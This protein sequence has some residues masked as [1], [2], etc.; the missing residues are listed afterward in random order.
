[1]MQLVNGSMVDY[2]RTARR[3]PWS[4]LPAVVQHRLATE[5]GAPVESMTLAGGGFTNGF[6]ALLAGGDRRLFAKAAPSTDSMIFDAYV[7]EAEVLAALP[8]GLPIPLLRSSDLLSAGGTQWQ[9]LCFEAVDGSMPGRP[10]TSGD[11]GAIHESLLGV[12]SGLQRLSPGLSG[13]SMVD[14]FFG[15]GARTDVF[16]RLARNGAA[17]AYL[18]TLSVRRMLDLQALAELG[19][20]ALIGDSVLHNDLRADNI[21]ISRGGAQTEPPR[22]VFC[23]WNFLSTGPPW[24]DWVALLVYPRSAGIDVDHLLAESPLSAG[25]EPDHVDAWL[26][27]LASYMITSGAQPELSSSPQLR[28]HQRFTARILIDWLNKRR[29]WES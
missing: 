6:A 13:P 22:A 15:D 20:D 26:A 11:L 5:L 2:S 24:A 7:R 16:A 29:K 1:M 21:I 25:A 10:W 12:Q 3:P 23:D 17:P 19:A 14:E 27:V 9:V 4:S 18:P 28:P 8:Q